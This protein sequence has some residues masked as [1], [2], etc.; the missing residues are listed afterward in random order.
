MNWR[1]RD[2]HFMQHVASASLGISA[3][4]RWNPYFEMFAFSRN[5]AD[6]SS[7]VAINTGALYV[8]SPRLALDGGVQFGLT[9][10]APAFSA[11]AG[12]SVAVGVLNRRA[13]HIDRRVPVVTST[14]TF[15]N[16]D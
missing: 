12:V 4:D 3:T 2:S 7:V 8:T 6:G 14:S 15:P 9:D 10:D 16:R 11:F 5:R 1:D 13:S